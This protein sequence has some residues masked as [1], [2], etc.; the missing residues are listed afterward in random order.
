MGLRTNVSCWT[1]REDVF[2]LTCN[3]AGTDEVVSVVVHERKREKKQRRQEMVETRH[4]F[5]FGT[6]K[7]HRPEGR[8]AAPTKGR[9]K[10]APRNG[11]SHQTDVQRE[12]VDI[13]QLSESGPHLCMRSRPSSLTCCDRRQHVRRLA[14]RRS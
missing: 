3:T 10:T 6:D 2:F 4:P 14:S 8:K 7:P 13:V 5:G 12:R 1:S 9:G 11:E